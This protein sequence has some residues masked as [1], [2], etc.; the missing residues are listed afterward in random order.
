MRDADA[1]AMNAAESSGGKKSYS[2]LV[3]GYRQAE[4]VAVMIHVGHELGIFRAMANAGPMTAQQLAQATG[5]HERWLL[6]W[7][8]LQA[9]AKILVYVPED[10]FMLPEEATDI[11]ANDASPAFAAES[12]TG[13]YTPAQVS[14][15]IESFRTGIGKTYESDGAEAVTRSEA[16]H[17]RSAEKQVVPHMI[18]ALEGVE[19]KLRRGALVADVGC[20]DGALAVALA[21]AFPKSQIHAM[22]PNAHAVEHVRKR[23]QEQG[24]GNLSVFVAPAE[25]FPT[26]DPYDLIITFDCI[27]DMTAPQEAIDEIHRRLKPDGTW[28][29]KDI[30]SKP[31]FEENLRNPMLAMMYGFSLFSCMASAMSEPGGAG[32]GT[33]GFNPEVAESMSRTAGFTRFRMLDFKD[34]GNLYYEVR[35]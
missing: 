21:K 13:G 19:E 7:M 3:W 28:F 9:A 35:P 10:R 26:Q 8:R 24:L 2:S 34:P 32:L 29:V 16:R 31:S 18:P 12:F 33:L 20:G 30:R 22:D 15:L 4:T 1:R 14:G 11:L 25:R 5:L 27:H 17:I 23:A 6:E